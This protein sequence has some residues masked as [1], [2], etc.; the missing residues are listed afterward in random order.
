MSFGVGVLVGGVGVFGLAWGLRTLFDLQVEKSKKR[1]LK[2]LGAFFVLVG[3]FLLSVGIVKYA[4]DR[5]LNTM[6]LGL[7][8]CL[9]IFVWSL[10]FL[11]PK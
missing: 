2:A 3:Q 4:S 8:L 9:S 1:P 10:G 7:G 11:R 6:H 5:G